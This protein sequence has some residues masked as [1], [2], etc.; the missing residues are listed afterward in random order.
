M[1]YEIRLKTRDEDMCVDYAYE[2]D[3]ALDLL[4]E[5]KQFHYADQLRIEVYNSNLLEELEMNEP[6]RVIE[7]LAITH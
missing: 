6:V 4:E 1:Y 2:E 7:G 5:Q 3:E